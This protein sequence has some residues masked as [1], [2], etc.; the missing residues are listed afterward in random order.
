MYY[1]YQAHEL[2]ERQIDPETD[3]KKIEPQVLG[4]IVYQFL[5]Y[6]QVKESERLTQRNIR[7]KEN[8]LGSLMDRGLGQK[9]RPKNAKNGN[10]KVDS[11]DES[12]KE[13]Q[14]PI[15]YAYSENFPELPDFDGK[16]KKIKEA[17]DRR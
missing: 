7:L 11:S 5:D 9:I 13:D 15:G 16:G 2:L 8:P 10:K 12:E 17:A 6:L 1:E 14:V 4:T 3:K